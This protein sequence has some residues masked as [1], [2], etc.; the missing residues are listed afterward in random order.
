[1]K[2]LTRRQ[3]GSKYAATYRARRKLTKAGQWPGFILV[4]DTVA[5]HITVTFD[6]GELTG[7]FK[8]DMQTIERIGQQR[9]NS[10]VS[11][12]FVIDMK[13]GMVGVGQPLDSKGTH[14]VNDFGKKGYSHDQNLKARAIA[15]MGMPGDKVYPAAEKALVNL[16]V[17]MWEC[18]YI[19]KDFDY[20]PHSFFTAK[21]CPTSAVREIMPRVREKV[22]RHI[23]NIEAERN[24][25]K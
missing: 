15:F 4:V 23:R 10:G 17:A 1:V 8:I 24:K 14:T 2:V 16:L 25:K 3:W 12:N 7:D 6:S 18:G 19:T 11:Y 22:A 20:Q 13:T 21:D 5:Q 9:F